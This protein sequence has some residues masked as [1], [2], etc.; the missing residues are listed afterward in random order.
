MLGAIGVVQLKSAV[1]VAVATDAAVQNGVWIRPFSD[2]IYTM[3]PYIASE[4]DVQQICTGIAA[5]VESQ[6]AIGVA[7]P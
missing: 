2:L 5:A 6:A 7:R 4:V 3:P 1:D